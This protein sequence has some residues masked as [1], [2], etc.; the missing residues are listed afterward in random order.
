M[1]WELIQ[2]IRYRLDHPEKVP[3]KSWWAVYREDIRT[4]LKIIEE[5]ENERREERQRIEKIIKR[6]S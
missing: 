2:A 4:L 1:R 3:G 6:D 5:N